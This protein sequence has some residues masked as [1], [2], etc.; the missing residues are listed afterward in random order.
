MPRDP[1]FGRL[2][3]TRSSFSY[4]PVVLTVTVMGCDVRLRQNQP[5]V[6]ANFAVNDPSAFSRIPTRMTAIGTRTAAAMPGL[7]ARIVLVIC[8]SVGLA[9]TLVAS[10]IVASLGMRHASRRWP[11]L[12]GILRKLPFVSC[13][14][15]AAVGLYV[16]YEGLSRIAG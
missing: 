13:A 9:L 8:F 15:V 7:R 6:P 11:R 5:W 14:L 12:D 2:Y 16:G 10:G 4:R 1:P 3:F